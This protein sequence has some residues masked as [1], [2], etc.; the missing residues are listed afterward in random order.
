MMKAS[1]ELLRQRQFLWGVFALRAVNSRE[2][3]YYA[4][5]CFGIDQRFSILQYCVKKIGQLHLMVMSH[6]VPGPRPVFAIPYFEV[7]LL[8]LHGP[9]IVE[10]RVHFFRD[11]RDEGRSA[12][13]LSSDGRSRR[14]M[15]VNLSPQSGALRVTQDNRTHPSAFKADRGNHG[16]VHLYTRMVISVPVAMQFHCG[17]HEPTHQVEIMR[18]LAHNHAA[19]FAGPCPA[20][21]VGAVVGGF[22]PSEHGHNC[23]HWFAE[24]AGIDR[25]LHPEDRFIPAALTD[26]P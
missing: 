3:F 9:N 1:R 17:T 6:H 23:E 12:I 16:I 4:T 5:S 7:L 18:S 13:R 21:R 15:N 26:D 10:R 11:A 20:P 25:F 19:A 8:P 14:A 24:F 22:T 2:Q